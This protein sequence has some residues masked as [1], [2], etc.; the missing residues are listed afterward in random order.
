MKGRGE[1]RKKEKRIKGKRVIEM[2]R[3]EGR[4][5]EDTIGSTVKNDRA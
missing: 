2:G 1:K 4:R 5:R 3:K